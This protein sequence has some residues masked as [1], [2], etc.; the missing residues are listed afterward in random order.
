MSGLKSCLEFE[1]NLRLECTAGLPYRNSGGAVPHANRSLA[2]K[3]RIFQTVKIIPQT[4][5]PMLATKK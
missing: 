4:A 2:K 1:D 3:Y 5:L